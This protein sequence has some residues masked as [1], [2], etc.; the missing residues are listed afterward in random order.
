MRISKKTIFSILC[1]LLTL[2][3]ISAVILYPV[4]HYELRHYR[5]ANLRASL[6]GQIDYLFL[7]ASHGVAS[8]QPVTV[9]AELGNFSYNLSSQLM[10]WNS[11]IYMLEKELARNPVKH[12]VFEVAFDSLYRDETSEFAEG[13]AITVQRLDSFGEVLD[14]MLKNVSINDWLNI[15]SRLLASGVSQ[16]GDLLRGDTSQ[17]VHY[18]NRGY[19]AKG[20]NAL[21]YEGGPSW[22]ICTT[23]LPENVQRLEQMIQMCK[24]A[25]VTCSI[26]VVPVS[27]AY[28][29]AAEGWDDFY[30]YMKQF[31]QEQDCEFYDFNLLRDRYSLFSDAYSFY[32]VSHMSVQGATAFSTAYAD[33][34]KRVQNQ[35]SIDKLFYDS[36]HEMLQ[37]S[38]YAQ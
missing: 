31:C 19:Y 33:V 38:P 18:A 27:D 16:W 36:Y 13:T 22:E 35:E 5:D 32:D 34:M 23:Y 30:L 15:Y 2:I 6:A 8:Y 29:C 12:V 25:Q 17:Q 14:F 7:G 28:L 24:D 10:D 3:L 20:P 11:K 4:Y 1:F 21:A 26:V 9:D 37:D